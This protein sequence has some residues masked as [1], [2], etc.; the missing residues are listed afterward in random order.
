MAAT[1]SASRSR[2]GT[3]AQRSRSVAP[4]GK[5]AKTRR[6]PAGHAG[7]RCSGP[8]SH[9]WDASKTGPDG[10]ANNFDPGACSMTRRPRI[11]PPP[12]LAS[13]W[14]RCRRL[15]VSPPNN[16]W[17]RSHYKRH[18]NLTM[19]SNH[20]LSHSPCHPLCRTHIT[21]VAPTCSLSLLSPGPLSRSGHELGRSGTPLPTQPGSPA[22]CPAALVPASVVRQPDSPRRKGRLWLNTAPPAAIF[23]PQ[24]PAEALDRASTRVH[25][26]A[27]S[28]SLATVRV[29]WA[30]RRRRCRPRRFRGSSGRPD[31][32][33]DSPSPLPPTI[34]PR[35]PMAVTRTRR[36]AWAATPPSRPRILTMAK[37]ASGSAGG[38]E[39]R[40]EPAHHADRA[41]RIEAAKAEASRPKF[42][43]PA[44]GR[45]HLG[46][47][48]PVGSDPL[49]DG[50]RKQHRHPDLRGRRR[51]GHRGR[52]GQRLR[53]VGPRPA[54]RRHDHRLRPHRQVSRFRRARRSR[55][56][57]RSP[58][59]ATEVSPPDRTCTSRCGT[60][61]A[62]RSTRVLAGPAR[63]RI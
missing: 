1:R 62:R 24:R 34:S 57:S 37:T 17:R 38:R 56:A 6:P 55:R 11:A 63:R 3:S 41:A 20:W 42:F 8:H 27:A 40:R 53:P 50:H 39:D 10:Q 2:M 22:R 14:M 15:C 47:R 44:E 61:A 13:S 21:A 33:A 36:W 43:L 29:T 5:T 26:G 52:T 35:W 7:L 18:I 58:G 54:R 31:A 23:S 19:R 4:S 45:L 9:Q 49:R 16:E 12:G 25:R 51:R 59:W 28:A 48:R 46:L 30:G 60:T 32:E